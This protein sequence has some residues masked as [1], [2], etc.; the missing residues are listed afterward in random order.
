MPTPTLNVPPIIQE[1]PLGLKKFHENNSARI[2]DV[3]SQRAN[4]DLL[5]SLIQD[6]PTAAV[7]NAAVDGIFDAGSILIV[8]SNDA[9][10]EATISDSIK[11]VWLQSYH[12]GSR[13]GR[14]VKRL[15][16]DA[17]LAALQYPASAST[18]SADGK[19]WVIDERELTPA[20]FGWTGEDQNSDWQAVRDAVQTGLTTDLVTKVIL[21]SSGGD[22]Y[23]PFLA[24]ISTENITRP[25]ALVVEGAGPYATQIYA[26]K[27]NSYR[28]EIKGTWN[29][30]TDTPDLSA[31]SPAIG[32]AYVCTAYGDPGLAGIGPLNVGDMVYR[33]KQSQWQRIIAPSRPL[34]DWD[35]T[36]NTPEL[37]FGADAEGKYFDGM[38]VTVQVAGTVA[39]LGGLS[40][41]VGDELYY[42]KFNNTWYK[43]Q[44]QGGNYR[45]GWNPSTNSPALG[46]GGTGGVAGDWFIVTADGN[47]QLDGGL[48]WRRGDKLEHDGAG[49]FRAYASP[50]AAGAWDAS[51]ATVRAEVFTGGIKQRV[52]KPIVSGQGVRG[53]WYYVRKPGNTTLNGNT[54][55]LQDEIALFND[56][57]AWEKVARD[58]RHDVGIFDFV[59]TGYQGVIHFRNVQFASLLHVDDDEGYNAGRLIS[60]RNMNSPVNEGGSFSDLSLIFEDTTSVSEDADYGVMRQKLNVFESCLYGHNLSN[61]YC[62]DSTFR[63][64]L[65][66]GSTS[67]D[68]RFPRNGYAAVH[69]Q[70]PYLPGVHNVRSNGPAHINVFLEGLTH[71]KEGDSWEGGEVLNL[72]AAE[73]DYNLVVLH[74]KPMGWGLEPT[75]KLSGFDFKAKVAG[76]YFKGHSGVTFTN[77]Q[78]LLWD[79]AEGADRGNKISAAIMMMDGG[80][81]I[82]DNFIPSG[83]YHVSNSE[84]SPVIWI[85]GY[86]AGI[87]ADGM[88]WGN[89]GVAIIARNKQGPNAF[90]TPKSII[91][92]GTTDRYT[93]IGADLALLADDPYGNVLYEDMSG[94]KRTL[95]HAH[96]GSTY[97]PIDSVY[98]RRND[99]ASAP[100]VPLGARIFEGLTSTGARREIGGLYASLLDNTE[101]AVR[102]RLLMRALQDGVLVD[103]L[104]LR[105]PNT[106][107]N[108]SLI[109]TK[110]LSGTLTQSRVKVTEPGAV[111]GVAGRVVYID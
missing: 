66:Q 110:R 34:A 109:L 44:K 52:N 86:S 38:F 67:R 33:N 92:K 70:H 42:V 45:G 18:T 32:D 104:D 69:F 36:T 61:P 53:K 11:F 58:P 56:N 51:I 76:A 30:G 84:T 87:L 101:G 88:M 16:S 99:Y 103:A 43:K 12:A 106:D 9:L 48:L 23:A 1:T 37:F 25:N 75:M 82:I 71:D 62:G 85:G 96:S 2:V 73:A 77:S 13:F 20:M 3:A 14:H 72:N 93:G 94:N 91:V 47:L 26:T 28:F 90:I 29:G 108:T 5:D 17:E 7:V 68:K 83:G 97:G 19:K 49:W 39:A 10:E 80:S 22:Y 6:R 57:G 31:L 55:W 54:N 89:F 95:Q 40:V 64:P 50:Y 4:M 98:A 100:A 78:P 24:K 35:P 41:A 81:F 21:D 107:N 74:N 15:I 63:F 60:S 111:S 65:D 59:H 27:A 102:S 46:L 105:I 79:G 8:S